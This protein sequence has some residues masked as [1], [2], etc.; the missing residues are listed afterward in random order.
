MRNRHIERMRRMAK[1]FHRNDRTTH[2]ERGGIIAHHD[3]RHVASDK[4]TWWDDVGFILNDYRVFVHL[5]HPRMR[6]HDLIEEKALRITDHLYPDNLFRKITPIFK[7]IGRSRK[8]RVSSR[9]ESIGRDEWFN[10]VMVEEARLYQEADYRVEPSMKTGWGRYSRWMELCV[11]IEVRNEDDLRTLAL[12]A[13]RLLKRETTVDREFPSYCYTKADW[14]GDRPEPNRLHIHTLRGTLPK[15]DKPVPIEEMN[16]AIAKR[17]AKSLKGAVKH[18]DEPTAPVDVEWD[19]AQS[20]SKAHAER[21][22]GLLKGQIEMA[23]DFDA[24][25]PDGIQ[26]GFEGVC[27]AITRTPEEQAWLDMAPVGC[28]F[29]SPDYERLMAEEARPEN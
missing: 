16:D 20:L 8:K 22:Y 4:L 14:E 1:R 9:I 21:K 7:K 28:E 24:P 26:A 29:G 19:P 23:D 3:Y 11:P 18:F 25:L 15:A 2:F 5:V 10:A 27:Q 6:Y 17:G 12:L 13:K